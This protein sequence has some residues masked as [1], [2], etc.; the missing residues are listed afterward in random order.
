MTPTAKKTPV[1]KPARRSP[2]RFYAALGIV[3]VAGVALIAW[4]ANRPR[5]EGRAVA[6]ATGA[7]VRAEPWVL[8]NPAAPV[9]IAEFADFECPACANYA[10]ITGP[11]VKTRLIETGR[12]KLHFYP[13]PLQIHPNTW[14]ASLAAAC[15]GDQGKFWEMHDRLF[16][17]QLEWNSQAT[18]NPRKVMRGYA[19]ELGL[20]GDKY[21]QCMES[22]VHRP[23]IQASYDYAVATNVGQ[24]PSFLIGGR[25]YAG[26]LPYDEIKRLVDEAAAAAGTATP[27]ATPTA[28]PAAT[29]SPAGR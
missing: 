9:T 28:S 10:T 20:D 3:G 22:E 8:G 7:P 14:D 27:T 19:Q 1:R 25:V 29:A 13:F 6:P 16:A 5:D 18:R 11:D 21:A 15:A 23:R 2:G 26:S 24:T 4:L 17:G 12:A